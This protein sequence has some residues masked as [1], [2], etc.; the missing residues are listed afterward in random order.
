MRA[1]LPH[2]QYYL[3]IFLAN[4]QDPTEVEQRPISRIP[5]L[6]ELLGSLVIELRPGVMLR[7][8]P[9]AG[10]EEDDSDELYSVARLLRAARSVRPTIASADASVQP[11]R[12]PHYVSVK[13]EDEDYDLFLAELVSTVVIKKADGTLSQLAYVRW[14]DDTHLQE[15]LGDLQVCE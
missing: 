5:K 6:S 3:R 9:P 11:E 4:P 12:Y 10:S 13:H 2:M 8:P 15:D 1:R 7:A 14:C